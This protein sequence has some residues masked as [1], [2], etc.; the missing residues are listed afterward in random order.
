[1]NRMTRIAAGAVALGGLAVFPAMCEADGNQLFL[2]DFE[3][4]SAARPGK[5]EIVSG[6]TSPGLL[7]QTRMGVYRGAKVTVVSKDEGWIVPASGKVRF[8]YGYRLY[9][10]GDGRRV[11]SK[12]ATRF[13]D[14]GEHVDF[15]VTHDPASPMLVAEFGTAKLEIPYDAL[16][17]DFT[18]AFDDSGNAELAVT[19]LSDS[20]RRSARATLPFFGTPRR[21]FSVKTVLGSCASGEKAEVKLDNLSAA[22]ATPER[23]LGDIPARIEPL[24]T[25]DPVKAGWKLA[26]R[27]EFDGDAIDRSKWDARR[28]SGFEHIKVKDGKLAIEVVRRPD[29][30]GLETGSIWTKESFLYGY[31]EARVRFTR[32]NGWWAAFWLYGDTVE[33]PFLDGF[34]IDIFEDYYTRWLDAQGR[35]KAFIDH[36][37]HMYCNATLKSWNYME[38]LKGSLDDF[39]T[40]AVKWT[41]FEITYYMDGKVAESCAA[42]S[43][44]STVTFD[45]FN[46]GVGAVPLK[47]ILSGQIMKQDQAWLRGIND[48]SACT[49]PDRYYVDWIRIYSYPWEAS[50]RPSVAWGER[51]ASGRFNLVLEGDS[52]TYRVDVKPAA[53]TA[54]PI[55]AVYLFDS[56]YLLAWKKEPPFEFK[57]DF[58]EGYFNATDYMRPGRQRA[59]P[60]FDGD[61]ALVAFAEDEAGGISKTDP[62]EFYIVSEKAKSRPYEGKAHVIP[63][64]INPA[65]FDEGGQ[66]VAYSDG[67]KGNM[68]GK[69]DNWRMDEDVDCTPTGIGGVGGGEWLNY[70]VDIAEEGDYEVS[71]RYGTPSQGKQSM[72]FLCDLKVVG[73]VECIPQDVKYGWNTRSTAKTVLHLPGGR[74][75]IRLLLNG[76]YNFTT[77]TFTRK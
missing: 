31:F 62:I 49:F 27:D 53:K 9:G 51:Y 22:I 38:P 28:E 69:R 35:S 45:P 68:H 57:V 71:F 8:A 21:K 34:E 73:S 4:A 47:A 10:F 44:W 52:Q 48:Y 61:H 55:R 50:G 33:N 6:M 11:P 30:K 77:L 26:F 2:D 16:P 32:Q 18:F 42:H 59:K 66:G 7:S 25:F 41:P 37:L 14:G 74:H 29:G 12:L 24:R 63:G 54:S 39:H 36:N 46:H 60:R 75:V 13:A 19:S 67:S 64:E 56:G 3:V 65:R 43:P 15:V 5:P 1:M 23:K 76:S 70:T 40:I 58:T 20:Q 17:A 72:V